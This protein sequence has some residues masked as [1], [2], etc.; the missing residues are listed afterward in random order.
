M[1]RSITAIVIAL[2]LSTLASAQATFRAPEAG[3]MQFS[4][5]LGSS[6]FS[7]YSGSLGYDYLLPYSN[8]DG[9]SIGFGS[10]PLTYI[11]LGGMN[12]N[13]IVS[14]VGIR[15][16]YFVHERFDVNV[17]FGMN[18]N[19][20]PKKDFIEGD[21]SI[22]QMPIPDYDCIYGRTH[23]AFFVEI[24]TNFYF[25]PDNE[26]IAPYVG[27]EFGYQFAR[28]ETMM[29]YTGEVTDDGTP[30][31][32]YEPSY[33]AGQAWALRGGFVAGIDYS[34]APGLIL[35]VEVSPAMYQCSVLEIHPSGMT[36]YR[37]LNHDI[38]L[39]TMPKVK[40]AFRF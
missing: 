4:L 36:P 37:A 21:N 34:V 10:K 17:M 12:N 7:L 23:H 39:F 2:A 38:K 20:T 3:D 11:D 29:P 6:G 8:G 16:S 19:L 27:V 26:R 14:T 31:E 24:G 1:K 5:L 28:V 15:Y 32:V 13:S 9:T 30:I 33:Q 35:G 25:L 22:P 18:M 40:L